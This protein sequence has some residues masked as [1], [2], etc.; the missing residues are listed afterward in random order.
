MIKDAD[1]TGDAAA[2]LNHQIFKHTGV[3]YSRKRNRPGQA[4]SETIQTGVASCTGLSVILIDAC[5]SVGIPARLV[6]TPL[7]SNMSGNH[8]WVEI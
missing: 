2:K 4:P 8:S 7:W 3:K 1:T 6:G 5:R